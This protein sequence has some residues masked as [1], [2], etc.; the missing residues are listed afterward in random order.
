L[1]DFTDSGALH[2]TPPR[3]TR[4][5]AQR[6]TPGLEGLECLIYH[7]GANDNVVCS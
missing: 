3:P 6:H 2:F 4:P 7:L 5:G 1:D